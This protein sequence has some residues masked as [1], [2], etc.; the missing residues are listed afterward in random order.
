MQCTKRVRK[1]HNSRTPL[2]HV[3]K[4]S[5]DIW[6]ARTLFVLVMCQHALFRTPGHHGWVQIV[7]PS[8]VFSLFLVADVFHRRQDWHL[9]A[10]AHFLFRFAF[11]CW[12][13]A[14]LIHERCHFWVGIS[15]LF[16]GYWGHIILKLLWVRSTRDFDEHQKSRVYWSGAAEM[17]LILVCLGTAHAGI[18]S[19]AYGGW[20]CE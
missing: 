5:L 20:R 10:L 1:N 7:F 3:T 17:V 18:V 16:V 9:N 2:P 12:I 11:Y 6:L 13:H 8:T 15:F 4:Y 14:A 19:G